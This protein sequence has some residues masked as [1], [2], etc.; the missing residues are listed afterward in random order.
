MDT[1]SASSSLMHEFK[2]QLGIVLGFTHLLV[3]ATGDD[4]P[5]KA[6]LR[7][8]YKAAHAALALLERLDQ[9][10]IPEALPIAPAVLAAR[11]Q[12]KAD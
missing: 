6:D 10:R 7:E 9:Q 5:R 11:C 12:T 2:N 8:V 3:A 1:R 4:D